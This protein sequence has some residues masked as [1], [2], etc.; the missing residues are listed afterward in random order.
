MALDSASKLADRY[1]SLFTLPTFKRIILYLLLSCLAIGVLNGVFSSLTMYGF[2][3]GLIFGF[4]LF[5]LS[6]ASECLVVWLLIKDD[7]VMDLRRCSFL[8]LASNSILFL[9]MIIACLADIYLGI[10]VWIKVMAV[11]FYSALTLRLVVFSSISSYSHMRITLS[12]LIQP[13]SFLMALTLMRTTQ[14]NPNLLL[15][16]LAATIASLTATHLFTHLVN[17]VGRK[18]IG[19][20]SISLFRAFLMNWTENINCL[21]YT[22][23]SPRDRG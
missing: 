22:S 16:P 21:L 19:F 2:I 17:E 20:P 11:G 10:G 7:P 12:S 18:E 5:G 4:I 23:P 14:F 3:I 9:F 8:S 6:L 15:A 13:A 1:S